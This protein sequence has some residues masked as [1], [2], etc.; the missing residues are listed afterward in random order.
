MIF[1]VLFGPTILALTLVFPKP[2]AL[3]QRHW[4]VVLAPYGLGAGVLAGMIV[5][6]EVVIGW[7]ATLGMLLASAIILLHSWFTL[8]D[9]VSRARCVG[10]WGAFF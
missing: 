5:T 2:K 1:G 4:W 6:D 3:V 7:G 9:A 10:R 8:R